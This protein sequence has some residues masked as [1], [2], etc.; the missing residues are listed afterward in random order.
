VT[1]CVISPEVVMRR[2]T[3]ERV[4]PYD[5]RLPYTGDL[6]MW[7]A[8][9]AIAD[10]GHIA[11]PPAAF[12]RVH[13]HNMHIDTFR[14]GE[15]DGMLL[16]L[17]QRRTT[18]EAV[19]DGPAGDLEEAD[20]LRDTAMRALAAD[21]LAAASTAYT[22]GLAARWPITGLIDFAAETTPA[23]RSLRQ[24]R[25]LSRRRAVGE[26]LARRNPAFVLTELATRLNRSGREHVQEQLGI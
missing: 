17:R 26:R 19:F 12:Y 3:Y 15:V 5:P 6:A 13:G 20:A 24:W 16:E 18:I 11:G 9:A 1:N 22:W 8:A 23:Y 21:A 7:M 10:V 4:G 14:S 2:T 25:G